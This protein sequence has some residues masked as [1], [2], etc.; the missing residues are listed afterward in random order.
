[1]FYQNPNYSWS[2]ISFNYTQLILADFGAG[3]VLIS[4]GAILGKC[5][6]F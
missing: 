5:S 2:K 1:M 3:A 6:I 4:F